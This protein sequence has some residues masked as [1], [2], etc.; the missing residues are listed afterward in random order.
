VEAICG[1][2]G[3]TDQIAYVIALKNTKLSYLY[4]R[5]LQSNSYYCE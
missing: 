3:L 4:S 1:V 5:Q 2:F